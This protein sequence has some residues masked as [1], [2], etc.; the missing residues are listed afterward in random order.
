MYGLPV[1]FFA[2]ISSEIPMFLSLPT[3]MTVIA[4]FA[5][6][7]NLSD[8]GSHFFIFLFIALS[9]YIAAGGMGL[10]IGS[11]V[12]NKQVAISLTPVIIIPFLLFAGFFVN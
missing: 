1:Y 9:L 11:A 3:L 5:M 12:A 10:L 4:Y 8:G 6:N 7:L 2:K